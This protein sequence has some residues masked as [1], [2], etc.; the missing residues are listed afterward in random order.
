MRPAT[1]TPAGRPPV[2]PGRPAVT[3]HSHGPGHVPALRLVAQHRA[4]LDRYWPAAAVPVGPPLL[5]PELL[6]RGRRE[7]RRWDRTRSRAGSRAAF[8]A[9]FVVE[10]VVAVVTVVILG[11]PW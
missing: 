9:R 7:L 4:E 11:G 1:L 8:A 6:A 10:A 5:L 2:A 3:T